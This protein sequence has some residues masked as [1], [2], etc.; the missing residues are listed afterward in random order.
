M[1]TVVRAW[2]FSARKAMIAATAPVTAI[3]LSFIELPP[4]D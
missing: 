3:W 1:P 4:I 2:A